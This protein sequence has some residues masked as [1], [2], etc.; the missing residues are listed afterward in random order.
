VTV[1]SQNKRWKFKYHLQRVTFFGVF[2]LNALSQTLIG[3][4]LASQDIAAFTVFAL[5]A[6]LG[7]LLAFLDFGAG[8]IAQT[9]FLN[10]LRKGNLKS[11]L[12][13]KLALN[14]SAIISCLVVISG[15]ITLFLNLNQFVNLAAVYF[16]FLG[17]TIST[18]MYTNLLYA[19]GYSNLALILSRSSW[20]WS[21]LIIIVFSAYFKN[22]LYYVSVIAVIVQFFLGV[23]AAICCKLM[24]LFQDFVNIQLIQRDRLASYFCDY[25]LLAAATGFAAVPSILSLSADRY[26]VGYV[27]G[28]SSI[29]S[30]SAYGTFF[31]GSVGLL[32]FVFYRFRANVSSAEINSLQLKTRSFRTQVCLF[33]I[34]HFICGQLLVITVY[35]IEI[36]NFLMHLLYSLA[37]IFLGFALSYQIQTVTFDFQKYIAKCMILQSFVNLFLTFA[38]SYTI[39]PIG[40]A[41][42]TTI[43]LSLVLLPLLHYKNKRTNTWL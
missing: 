11:I 27:N 35:P 24:G 16:I 8:S 17:F 26:I 34:V 30:L 14:Q 12:F 29:A 9:N 4:W 13:V 6:G 1:K 38:L 5:I 41:L 3:A 37:L 25:K 36:S 20:F 7:N 42:S 19:K 22:N 10:Y 32:N 39:G 18:N 21:A 33:G 15:V 43:S 28:S 2:G 31:T 40:G 23:C